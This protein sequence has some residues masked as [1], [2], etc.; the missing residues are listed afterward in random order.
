MNRAFTVH[1][2][3]VK[4]AVVLGNCRQW[5][6][7]A[8][9]FR[10]Q[11]S[12]NLLRGL[13]RAHMVHAVQPCVLLLFQIQVVVEALP[14]QEVAFDV[15]DQVLD[16]AFLVAGAEHTQRRMKAKLSCKLLIRRMPDRL[17][18]CIPAQCD[19]LHIVAGHCSRHPTQRY[20]AGNQTMQQ[21]FLAHVVCE[22]DKHPAAVLEPGGKEVAGLPHKF[23]L[24][25]WKLPHFSPVDLE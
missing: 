22:P 21:R 15:L 18:L 13:A 12:R 14:Q 19:R 4:E 23:W 2:H 7:V 1:K 3:T 20:Q 8:A 11:C 24:C 25:E 16:T 10:Q 6:E 9:F 17:V 5:C